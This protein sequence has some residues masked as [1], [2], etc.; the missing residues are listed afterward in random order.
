MKTEASQ[1]TQPDGVTLNHLEAAGDAEG[2][3]SGWQEGHH[4]GGLM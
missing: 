4:G 2:E 1:E 3:A